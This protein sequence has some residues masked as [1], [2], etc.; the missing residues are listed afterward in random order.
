MTRVDQRSW[1]R[2]GLRKQFGEWGQL[3]SKKP[4]TCAGLN[5]QLGNLGEGVT[6]ATE[7]DTL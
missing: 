4:D 7:I 6:Q 3:G 2:E 1:L 5:T